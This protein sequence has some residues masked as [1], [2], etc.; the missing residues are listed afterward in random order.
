MRG[1]IWATVIERPEMVG[2]PELVEELSALVLGYL[3]RE[4]GPTPH[5]ER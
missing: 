2:D 4:P 3:R 1:A 5:P